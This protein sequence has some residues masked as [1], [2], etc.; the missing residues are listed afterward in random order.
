MR[1]LRDAAVLAMVAGL[2]AAAVSG[3]PGDAS[4][5][6]EGAGPEGSWSGVYDARH[7]SPD[8]GG[9]T[10]SVDEGA[11]GPADF[12]P[13]PDA[14]DAGSAAD[15]PDVLDSD[16]MAPLDGGA[17][18]G[19]DGDG[20]AGNVLGP[21]EG[22]G[23]NEDAGDGGTPD[24]RI[25]LPDDVAYVPPDAG[26]AFDC[27]D[28]EPEPQDWCAVSD[29]PRDA[30]A[31]AQE[32]TNVPAWEYCPDG[33]VE[34]YAVGDNAVYV[35]VDPYSTFEGRFVTLDKNGNVTGEQKYYSW[36]L[37]P[38]A[39]GPNGEVYLLDRH[40]W[41]VTW[42]FDE[43]GVP[44]FD[45]MDRECRGLPWA[46]AVAADGTVYV[47][48]SCFKPDDEHVRGVA[49]VKDGTVVWRRNDLDVDGRLSIGHDGTVYVSTPDGKI[50]ALGD[51]G[52]TKWV[53]TF[54]ECRASAFEIAVGKDNG[55]VTT[56]GNVVLSLDAEGHKRWEVGFD[57]G[58]L[59]P[60]VLDE[61]D[62]VVLISRGTRIFA[63]RIYVIAKCG[64]IKKAAAIERFEIYPGGRVVL[65][66]DASILL[67]GTNDKWQGEI[68]RLNRDLEPI[69]VEK[70]PIPTTGIQDVA[71]LGLAGCGDAYFVGFN[72]LQGKRCLYRTPFGNIGLAKSSWPM[73]RA[74]VRN[75]GSAN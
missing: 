70:P 54:P 41:L 10:P 67:A 12:G 32:D 49:A 23:S 1:F 36:H 26:A 22:D 14:G 7:P 5:Y 68:M 48:S 2:L 24:S 53:Y 42:P 29:D 75:T 38:P 30:S 51:G 17:E 11:D 8:T 15:A 52:N 47:S 35:T 20:D 64:A 34:G 50:F 62:N 31:P 61:D 58:D 3:C 71:M 63:A 69:A 46:P 66:S 9:E 39:I 74:N 57:E 33:W 72:E 56:I 43:A 59:G 60:P 37:S 25:C 19:G 21:D 16:S 13:A 55:I 27:N 73:W 4:V 40:G 44:V 65:A 18:D 28:H 6:Y 45:G